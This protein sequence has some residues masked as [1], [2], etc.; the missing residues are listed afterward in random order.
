[1]WVLCLSSCLG[2][3]IPALLTTIPAVSCVWRSVS[4]LQ[5]TFLCC[6]R[7]SVFCQGDRCNDLFAALIEFFETQR[8]IVEIK[9][10]IAQ[11]IE[12]HSEKLSE[13]L[14]TDCSV[15]T[16]GQNADIWEVPVLAGKVKSVADNEITTNIESSVVNLGLE[17]TT[18][19]R[20]L[21]KHDADLQ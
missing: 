12:N 4:V 8:T 9:S 10:T 1:M 6:L 20:L 21:D 11:A 2:N 7:E 14:L 19:L 5:M 16:W 3:Q 18:V 17:I 15:T 13:H